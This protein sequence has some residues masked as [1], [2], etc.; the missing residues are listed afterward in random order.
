MERNDLMGKLFNERM[1]NLGQLEKVTNKRN[2][3]GGVFSELR[4][5]QTPMASRQRQ[6]KLTKDLMRMFNEL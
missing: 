5:S 1:Q 4:K 6:N 3:R 2:Y